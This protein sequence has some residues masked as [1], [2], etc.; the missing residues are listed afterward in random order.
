MRL[1]LAALLLQRSFEICS[2]RLRPHSLPSIPRSVPA[3]SGSMDARDYAST[4]GARPNG[5]YLDYSMQRRSNP[6]GFEHQPNRYGVEGTYT[7]HHMRPGLTRGFGTYS[8]SPSQPQVNQLYPAHLQQLAPNANFQRALPPTG[9]GP[10]PGTHLPFNQSYSAA[11]PMLNSQ[12]SRG[13]TLPPVL[14]PGQQTRDLP[15][16]PIE[17]GQSH[18]LPPPPP[19]ASSHSQSSAQGHYAPAAPSLQNDY[20]QPM[21]A[22]AATNI[23]SSPLPNSP[24]APAAPQSQFPLE[25]IPLH[26][27]TAT[28]QMQSTDQEAVDEDELALA[29]ELSQKMAMEEQEREER[30]RREEEEQLQRVLAQS[31]LETSAFQ[32]ESFIFDDRADGPSSSKIMLDSTIPGRSESESGPSFASASGPSMQPQ[33]TGGSISREDLS[34]IAAGKRPEP[35]DDHVAIQSAFHLQQ[36]PASSSSSSEA[37]APILFQEEPEK[38]FRDST[39]LK[40]FDILPDNSRAPSPLQISHLAGRKENDDDD[41]DDEPLPITI[42]TPG[43]EADYSR[44]RFSPERSDSPTELAYCEASRSNT[45]IPRQSSLPA[46]TLEGDIEVGQPNEQLQ[47][48]ALSHLQHSPNP[49]VSEVANNLS[50]YSY[51][52]PSRPVNTLPPVANHLSS[53]FQPPEAQPSVTLGHTS[54]HQSPPRPPLEVPLSY[55]G[56]FVEGSEIV[57]SYRQLSNTNTPYQPA[58]LSSPEFLTSPQSPPASS[59]VSPGSGNIEW[60][61]SQGG[62]ADSVQANRASSSSSTGLPPGAAPAVPQVNAANQFI[63]PDLLMGVCTYP[64]T[65]AQLAV[66]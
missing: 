3:T 10:A 9:L 33:A 44:P 23:S 50:A 39:Q 15:P 8:G 35:I 42:S 59:V 66:F 37:A 2:F 12:L 30:L 1:N 53:A 34:S 21:H 5:A 64:G 40:N 19:I 58:P 36:V 22:P 17:V 13:A 6:D 27:P 7:N 60:A 26:E 61:P 32:Y 48:Q 29:I 11:P 41:A 43:E 62:I 18:S 63:D 55:Q 51:S 16:L 56:P 46:Y 54:V 47:M 14:H 25:N 28:Q 49:P 45:P 20:F 65:V 57:P 38:V 52:I 4:Q 24:P 31:M